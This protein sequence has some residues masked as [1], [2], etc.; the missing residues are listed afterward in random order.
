MHN[1][2]YIFY[3]FSN[4]GY[5]GEIYLLLHWCKRFLHSLLK[6]NN[7]HKRS[8]FLGVRF[9]SKI[10]LL[11]FF[12]VVNKFDRFIKRFPFEINLNWL[13]L[14]AIIEMTKIPYFH[15]PLLVQLTFKCTHHEAQEAE[16]FSRSWKTP[17]IRLKIN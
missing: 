1:K 3:S 13:P 10:S 7:F 17:A 8:T 14:K 11:N 15:V 2:I 4:V 9:K 16:A 12:I 6:K 5:K